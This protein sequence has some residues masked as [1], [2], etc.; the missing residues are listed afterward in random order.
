MEIFYSAKFVR[1]Y[2]KLDLKTKLLAE[3]RFEIFTT[4]QYDPRL[5]THR[6]SGSLAGYYSFSIN[7]KLR[8]IFEYDKNNDIWFLSIVSHDI[9]KH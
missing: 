5:K 8:I 6:L 4:D 2:S 9:Y 1:E 3:S 7:H